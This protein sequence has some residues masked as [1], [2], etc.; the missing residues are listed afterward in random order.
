MKNTQIFEQIKNKTLDEVESIIGK[1]YYYILSNYNND[2]GGRN[3]TVCLYRY[4]HLDK[5][6]QIFLLVFFDNKLTFWTEKKI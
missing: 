5:I 2:L 4:N 1:K 3:K 6:V